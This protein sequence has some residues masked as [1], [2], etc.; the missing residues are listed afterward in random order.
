MTD[1]SEALLCV[2]AG[3]SA[4]RAGWRDNGYR[5]VLRLA[6]GERYRFEFLYMES[7]VQSERGAFAGA[8]AD[9][10]AEDWV[11]SNT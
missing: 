6:A 8:H 1:F 4:Y 5:G 9:L 2:K 7:P 3:G 10:L 11:I